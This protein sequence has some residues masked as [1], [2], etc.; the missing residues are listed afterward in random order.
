MVFYVMKRDVKFVGIITERFCIAW[1]SL[2]LWFLLRMLIRDS[3]VDYHTVQD[4]MLC[5]AW[6]RIICML[7][8][9]NSSTYEHCLKATLQENHLKKPNAHSLHFIWSTQ[10]LWTVVLKGDRHIKAQQ[11]LGSWGARWGK[12]CGQ[13]NARWIRY[14]INIQ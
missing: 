7:A 12:A 14:T 9:A 1:I 13:L 3:I 4:R 8:K 6:G 2:C 11:L 10:Y 5:L